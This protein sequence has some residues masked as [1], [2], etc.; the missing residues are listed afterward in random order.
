[1]AF[2]RADAESGGLT[3]MNNVQLAIKG[4]VLV[5]VSIAIGATSWAVY[6][7]RGPAKDTM[8]KDERVAQKLGGGILK[9]SAALADSYGIEPG[10][11]LPIDCWHPRLFVDGRV[12]PNPSATLEMRAPFAGVV[13]PAGPLV[14]GTPVKPQQTLMRFEARFSQVERLDMQ[15]EAR[16]DGDP[17][18]G[19]RGRGQAP[20]GPGRSLE[21][22][23]AAE[24][25]ESD[26][27]DHRRPSARG[28]CRDRRPAGRQ[29]RSRAVAGAA[30]RFPPCAG[31]A[32]FP[33]VGWIHAAG[34]RR[35]G[36][37][38]H[39]AGTCRSPSSVASRPSG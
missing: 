20:S 33:A 17:R 22:S 21:T 9:I 34:R 18:Q 36:N 6:S 14:L 24:R 35:G 25:Q 10:S 30:G 32:R 27:R 29:R 31:T 23:A 13:V 38:R 11:A 1:M 28:D 4:L 16:R 7:L 12:L 2:H 15:F 8:P 39:A 3:L 26:H 5:A 19:G 37:D